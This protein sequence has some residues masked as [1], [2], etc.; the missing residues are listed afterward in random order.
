MNI[1]IKKLK[2]KLNNKIVGASAVLN[3]IGTH[4][5]HLASY[6]SGLKGKTI[7]ADIK[8]ISK[9]IKMDDNSVESSKLKNSNLKLL[10]NYN[11]RLNMLR[12]NS[13]LSIIPVE[14]ING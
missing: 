5:Y 9:K 2:W 1:L 6:I 14:Y 13:A 8:Q 12:L 7:F 11:K 10:W 3:E 4:S